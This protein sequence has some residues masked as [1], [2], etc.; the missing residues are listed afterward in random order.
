MGDLNVQVSFG[1]VENLARNEL[2]GMTYI[3]KCLPGIFFM[4]RQIVP[5][6][7]ASGVVLE[8]GSEANLT[9]ILSHEG[10]M[11]EQNEHAAI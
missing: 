8:R 6:H 3:E 4:E 2:P 7:F 1:I 11:N 9:T 5:E 10:P